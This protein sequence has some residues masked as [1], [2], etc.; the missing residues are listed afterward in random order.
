MHKSA[1]SGQLK[2]VSRQSKPRVLIVDEDSDFAD[3]LL[4][5]LALEGYEVEVAHNPRDAE[6]SLVSFQADVALIDIRVDQDRGRE[7]I[8][9]LKRLRQEVLCVAMSPYVTADTAVDA[10]KQGAYDYLCKPFHADELMATL[11]RC[12][13]RI[14]LARVNA[15]ATS[16]LRQAHVKLET[17]VAQRTASLHDEIAEHRHAEQTL[18]DSEARFRQ[19]ARMANLGHWTWD[20][21]AHKFLD[22]SEELAHIFGTTV[23][24]FLETYGDT[25]RYLKLVH[26]EDRVRYK[27]GILQAKR[28]SRD[29]DIE[30]RVVRL[31]DEVRH[32]REVGEP[33]VGDGDHVIRI[34]GTLQDVTDQKR[35]AQQLHETEERY[36][37]L[38][39]H[40]QG[41]IY[42]HD[43]D[44]IVLSLNPAATKLLGHE[45]GYATG[46]RMD[47]F[48]AP[49]ARAEFSGYLERMRKY[50][51]DSGLMRVIT[52]SGEHRTW[53]Y[54]N[55]VYRLQDEPLYV[56][57]HAQDITERVRAEKALERAHDQ[58]EKRV[59]ERTRELLHQ[60]SHDSLTG[61]VNRAE[62]DRRLQKLAETART[63]SIQHALCYMD[64]DQF[65]IINDTCGHVAGDELLRQLGQLLP[66]WI[67]KQDTLARLGGDEFGVLL[68]RCSL[69]KAER[70]ADN[71]RNGIENFRF[72]WGDESFH[73]GVSIG[74]VAISKSSSS[75]TAMLSA[76]DAACYAAKDQGR[77]RIHVTHEGDEELAR[78]YGEMQWVSRIQSALE[79]ERLQLVFQEI[80]PLQQDSVEG[81]HYELLLRM[82]DEQGRVVMPGS[83]L[84]AAE[85]FSVSGKLDRWVVETAFD[86]LAEHP[87]H[88]A[89]LY[90]CSINLSGH[91]L[92]DVAFLDFVS[93]AFDQFQVPRQKICF[94]VTES[95][96]IANLASATHFIKTLSSSGCQFALDD[97]GKGLSS[98]GYLRV[99]PVN[100][101][102]IDGMFVKN[103]IDNPIDL[104][105]V[106]SINEIGKV[107]NKKTIAEFVENEEILEKVREIGI[108]F[109][110]GYTLGRPRPIAEAL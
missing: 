103:I 95:A 2:D 100:F 38:V 54:Q 89:E 26:T 50:G 58:L 45:P 76:A 21:V 13:E 106:K 79:Q 85:R 83:F 29:Y 4:N 97:F 5:I 108:D 94:E 81:K 75:V 110:Q 101:L 20:N 33:I 84:S 35:V 87:D 55:T 90:L 53:L 62:F 31:D 93:R 30:Y 61:L 36:R 77:N 98:F 39:E 72:Q 11:G 82:E 15:V 18:R 51:S 73:V 6:Q 22:A 17:Q 48:F 71:M 67:R 88:L 49:S 3:I 102:K 1:I 63:E 23:D 14:N 28:R 96:A 12:I 78:R 65:K 104:A 80:V 105:M 57:G 92:G 64:L 99:L 109:A 40:S 91:S 86:W 10:L 43:F 41:L 68:E 8:T 34:V 70:V 24:T 44:G 66:N 27:E 42:T 52:E 60:A 59:Q 69:D 25:D 37:H 19:A 9:S 7:L 107:M 47:E 16:A 74:V 56:L 32:V 46:R